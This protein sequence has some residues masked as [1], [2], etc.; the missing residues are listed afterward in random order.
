M[1]GLGLAKV[2]CGR[3]SG[4]AW[5][6]R[7]LARL[8]C[9]AANA[10]TRSGRSSVWQR[11]GL[12]WAERG[13]ARLD[14]WV[15]DARTWAGQSAAWPTCRFAVSK[16]GARTCVV[17]FVRGHEHRTRRRQLAGQ[18]GARDAVGAVEARL[19]TVEV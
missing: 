17:D 15:A 18:L 10:R 8:N 6:E 5:A 14:W 19:G 12:A 3:G 11:F 16:R 7:G 13:L 9:C 4:L 1:R 2:R